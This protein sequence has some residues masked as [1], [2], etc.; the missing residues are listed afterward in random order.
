VNVPVIERRKPLT[1]NQRAKMHDENGSTCCI[2]LEPIP[3]GEP[4]IDE[5]IIPLALGGTNDMSNRGPAHVG[6]AKKKTQRD[7]QLIAKAKRVRARHLGIKKKSSF[8]G[9]RRFDGTPVRNPRA[10]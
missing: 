9:W 2:C 10:V 1:R 3:A 8:R 5:H 4:F 7:L 6:C